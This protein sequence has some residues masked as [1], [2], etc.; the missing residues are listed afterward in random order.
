MPFL[1]SD[2]NHRPC[3]TQRGT[4]TPG[5]IHQVNATKMKTVCRSFVEIFSI[6]PKT[7]SKL[8]WY[9]PMNMKKWLYCGAHLH[10]M[11]NSP[12]F[13]HLE[14]LR[15]PQSDILCT[16]LT[17]AQVFQTVNSP[18]ASP[19]GMLWSSCFSCFLKAQDDRK[20]TVPPERDC[21]PHH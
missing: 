1:C 3:A 17:N 11:K 7:N 5:F 19:S 14:F 13:H 4:R 18:V 2:R 15:S 10:M 16:A 20:K 8:G 21:S 12:H 6:K 9:G